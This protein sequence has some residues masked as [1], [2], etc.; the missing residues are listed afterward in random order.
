MF[1][2]PSTRARTL[3][4]PI[5]SS[6]LELLAEK[7]TAKTHARVDLMCS[8]N[9]HVVGMHPAYNNLQAYSPKHTL[10]HS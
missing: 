6:Y 1:S 8:C 3:D 4:E 9:A 2:N 5:R 10:K 7:R